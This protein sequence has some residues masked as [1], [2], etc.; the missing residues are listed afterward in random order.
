MQF[1]KAILL[2][3]ALTF[4][5]NIGEAQKNDS[6]L[7]IIHL[8]DGKTV[9]GV[10]IEVFHDN[11]V[12]IVFENEK[13]RILYNDIDRIEYNEI[14][15]RNPRYSNKVRNKQ[16][17]HVPSKNKI[18][19]NIMIDLH[20]GRGRNNWIEPGRGLSVS[21]GYR[22][23][24]KAILGVGLGFDSYDFNLNGSIIP[25]F[26]E[27]RYEFMDRSFTP[28]ATMRAGYGN[29]LSGGG[30]WNGGPT[31]KVGGVF[32]NPLVGIRLR[33]QKKGH[34]QFALGYKLQDYTEEGIEFRDGPNGQWLEST[35]IDKLRFQRFSINAS[36]M[37]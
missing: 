32:L 8:K 24:N 4:I 28:F 27:Y 36:L 14:D 26:A 11:Y 33:T 37:F 3:I 30:N 12:D 29:P 21:A 22:F 23:S 1:I 17:Y 31:D 25:V 19:L 13:T 20:M 16:T 35:Y 7:D 10:I 5:A 18:Y 2:V 15:N 9:E 34:F 6:A